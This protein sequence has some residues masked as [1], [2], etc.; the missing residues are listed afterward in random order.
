MVWPLARPSHPGTHDWHHSKSNGLAESAVKAA[1]R[2]IRKCNKTGESVFLGLLELR[3]TPT[4]NVGRSPAQR[5]FNRRT[6]TLLPT[7]KNALKPQFSE[8]DL[9][10][11]KFDKRRQAFYHDK[12]SKL[13]PQLEEGD[14]VR[15][16]PFKLGQK[17]WQKGVVLKQLDDKSYNVVGEGGNVFRRNRVHLRQTKER[18]L[19]QETPNVPC[20]VQAP[21]TVPEPPNPRTGMSLRPHQYHRGKYQIL[22]LSQNQVLIQLKIGDRKETL[23]NLNIYRIT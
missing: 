5:L 12:N 13:L 10:K 3:N 11:I 18:P 22:K 7:T 21:E 9:D 8:N 20:Q 14:A 15:L 6:K 17:S 16:K 1:K 2:L 19:S 4:Q 23:R